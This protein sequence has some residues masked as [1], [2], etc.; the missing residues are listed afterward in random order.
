LSYI[1]SSVIG[2][3]LVEWLQIKQ[4]FR[5]VGSIGLLITLIVFIISFKFKKLTDL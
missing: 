3:F 5:M 1:F 4:S 2:G